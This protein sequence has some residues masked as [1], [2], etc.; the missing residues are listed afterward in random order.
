MRAA[1]SFAV[2]AFASCTVGPEAE[3]ETSNDIS[4][5]VAGLAESSDSVNWQP[6]VGCQATPKSPVVPCDGELIWPSDQS[7]KSVQVLYRKGPDMAEGSTFL[8]FV[9]WNDTTV[10]RILLTTVGRNGAHLRNTINNITAVRTS[11]APDHSTGSAG[12][13]IGGNPPQPPQPHIDVAIHFSQKYL[14]AAKTAAK[15]IHT[16]GEEFTAYSE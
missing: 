14:T 10:G 11:G 15:A 8:A 9:V 7:I 6:E 16:A 2:V 5:Q 12:S 1:A 4:V 3:T 13:A